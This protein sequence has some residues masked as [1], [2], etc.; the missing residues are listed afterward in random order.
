MKPKYAFISLVGILTLVV[1][2]SRPLAQDYGRSR[3]VLPDGPSSDRVP[4]AV[5]L[6]PVSERFE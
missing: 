4:S 1:V 5:A 2:A 3:N 6:P